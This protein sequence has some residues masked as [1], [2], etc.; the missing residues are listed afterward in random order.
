M[1]Q[2]PLPRIPWL[3]STDENQLCLVNFESKKKTVP[4]LSMEADPR[5]RTFLKDVLMKDGTV[6]FE[7]H[8]HWWR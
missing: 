8:S 3:G 7:N 5:T 1:L 4:S 2:P 6:S